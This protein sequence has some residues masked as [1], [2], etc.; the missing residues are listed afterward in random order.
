MRIQI[1]EAAVA[2]P[3]ASPGLCHFNIGEKYEAC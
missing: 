1:F 2:G 3:D